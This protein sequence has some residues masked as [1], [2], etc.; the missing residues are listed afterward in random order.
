MNEITLTG[1]VS[2]LQDL[3]LT[4]TGDAVTSFDIAVEDR[5]FDQRRGEWV[6][7]K[8]VFQR[9]VVY[10]RLAENVAHT[11]TVGTAVTVTGKIADDSWTPDGAEYPVTRTKLEATDVAVSLR[12][13]TA[14][15]TRNGKDGAQRGSAVDSPRS[16]E[17]GQVLTGEQQLARAS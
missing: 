1:N 10:R 11:L 9:V 7:K 8:A 2:K 14:E 17:I 4:S 16:T 15:V 13:A 12:F 3:R 6:A 5:Y